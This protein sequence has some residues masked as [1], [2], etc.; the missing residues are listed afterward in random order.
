[1]PLGLHVPVAERPA[2]K[3]CGL[4]RRQDVL[5]ADALGVEYLGVVVTGGFSRSVT[6]S[7]AER[8]LEGVEATR[9]AVLVDDPWKKTRRSA[10][11]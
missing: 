4:C 10:K 2:V 7:D 8:I 3:I 11:S 1:M 9:V 5:V 6:P